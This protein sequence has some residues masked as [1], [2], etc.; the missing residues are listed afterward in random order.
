MDGRGSQ[1][2]TPAGDSPHHR[3]DSVVPP[4]LIGEVR[5]T[6]P[7]ARRQIHHSHPDLEFNL[8]VR[9]GGTLTLDD[10]VY[11]LKPGTLI[12]IVPR[13]VHKLVRSPSLE[14]W[15]V[16]VGVE[17]LE[18][19]WV[20]DVAA[21]PARVVSGA[22]LIDLDRLLTQVAQ[23]SD[24]PVAYNAGVTYV[25]MRALRASRDRPS[26]S[27]KPM[28]P[29][30][31]RAL[32]LM[33]RSESPNSLSD[34]AAAAGVAPTYLSR[35]LQE[36]TGRNFIDWRNRIRLDR[37]MEAYEP[38]M[39]LLA[40]ALDAGFGSY[41]RFYHIFGEIVGCPPSEWLSRVDE[42]KIVPKAGAAAHVAGYGVPTGGLLS[43][44]Q[45]WTSLAPL[46]SPPIK[47]LLGERFAERVTS[48][49]PRGR[50][51]EWAAFDSLDPHPSPDEIDR[52][53]E[54]FDGQDPETAADYARMLAAHDLAG[55]YI[56]V[57]TDYGISPSGV[58]DLIASMMMMMWVGPKAA[59][60][61]TAQHAAIRRQV[62]SAL[63]SDLPR[64][65]PALAREAYVA[66]QCHHAILYKA[67]V[68]ARA[69][70]DPRLFDQLA[71]T[72]RAWSIAV[73]GS[74]ILDFEIT[75]EGFAQPASLQ[76]APRARRAV[77]A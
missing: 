52:L 55:I 11:E 21:R 69:S 65:D 53:V 44:R 12:W 75:P 63:D 51:L 41:A 76:P 45:R 36:H 39:N 32:L 37:F 23:D 18:Q 33:R 62:E 2:V 77:V 28:H 6:T 10:Q 56:R 64:I 30:V 47:A 40:A 60:V 72:I 4:G 9:G 14:M 67:S 50:R 20:A 16:T 57:C 22:E 42:G 3:R 38:G 71:N 73:L 15:V 13:Q 25:L 8:I 17:L 70:S 7:G 26:P 43:A 46:A 5:R 61:T 48:A 24:E 29:A 35:L 1:E 19:S 49:P 27:L 66:M 34:L 68:A 54:S 59:L 58:S 74:D 31:A